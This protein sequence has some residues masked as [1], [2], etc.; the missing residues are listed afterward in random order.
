MRLIKSV[1]FILVSRYSVKQ[2]VF[3]SRIYFFSLKNER[4]CPKL[5]IEDAKG[6]IGR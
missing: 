6:K 1:L 3:L 5:H 4:K 2:K